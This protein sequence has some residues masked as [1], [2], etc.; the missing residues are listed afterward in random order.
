MQM[1]KLDTHSFEGCQSNTVCEIRSNWRRLV[2]QA[3]Y[4]DTVPVFDF[5]VRYL[6]TQW[7][8]SLT[9]GGSIAYIYHILKMEETHKESD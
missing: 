7:I 8:S 3:L 9:V 5:D 2:S 6:A 1:I 4:E